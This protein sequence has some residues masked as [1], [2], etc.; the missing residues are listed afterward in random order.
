MKK[1]EI[2]RQVLNDYRDESER[3]HIPERSG[4][5]EEAIILSAL[6]KS[7]QTVG[8]D[9]NIQTCEDFGLLNVRCCKSCHGLY[10]HYEMS[11]VEVEP[12]GNAWVC[13]AVDRALNPRKYASRYHVPQHMTLNELL[14]AF[15]GRSEDA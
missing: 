6:E 13:C 15:M 12:V 3:A 14:T 9:T 11:L 4:V 2:V 1:L 5:A 7:L 8:P 10:Q